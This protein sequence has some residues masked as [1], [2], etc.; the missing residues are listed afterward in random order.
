MKIY[1]K[2]TVNRL[3]VNNKQINICKNNLRIHELSNINHKSDHS[4]DIIN[5]IDKFLQSKKNTSIL[6]YL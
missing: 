6:L 1:P 5:H 3:L 2:F 4:F